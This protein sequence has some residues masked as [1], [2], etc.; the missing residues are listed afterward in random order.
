[1]SRP[2]S[3]GN[4]RARTQ[5]ELVS[6]YTVAQDLD[7]LLRAR[8][9]T[10]T[11]RVDGLA[12]PLS[13]TVEDIHAHLGGTPHLEFV[14]SIGTDNAALTSAYDKLLSD[15]HLETLVVQAAWQVRRALIDA[16]VTK[17]VRDRAARPTD[18]S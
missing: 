16:A 6:V 3:P 13:L 18:P 4:R 12:D 2:T 10:L 11:V 7:Q 14:A 15:P 1:M 5:P 8:E 17:E 9:L